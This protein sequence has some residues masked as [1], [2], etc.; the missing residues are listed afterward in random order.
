MRRA[1]L[2]FWCLVTLVL[3]SAGSGA[4]LAQTTKPAGKE[5]IYP[6]LDAAVGVRL[7]LN[8]PWRASNWSPEP[9]ARQHAFRYQNGAIRLE[10]MDPGT[11]MAWQYSMANPI[12]LIENPIAVLRYRTDNKSSVGSILWIDDGTGPG[13]GGAT[14]FTRNELITDGQVHEL[15]KDVR[16]LFTRSKRPMGKLMTGL[17]WYL[18]CPADQPSASIDILEL[19]F[20]PESALLPAETQP[21]KLGNTQTQP[22]VGATAP[23]TSPPPAAAIKPVTATVTDQA[24]NPIAGATI[25]VNAEYANHA[26]NYTTD[27]KGHATL[28]PPPAVLADPSQ[29]ERYDLQR[30]FIVNTHAP[31]Y[32]TLRLWL[33][34]Q[35]SMTVSDEFE[36]VTKSIIL[37]RISTYGGT[38]RN[39]RDEPIPGAAV[40]LKLTP[41]FPQGSE[42]FDRST[43]TDPQGRWV[44]ADVP[45]NAKAEVLVRHPD[46]VSFPPDYTIQK[47]FQ[48]M[49]PV[50]HE[51]LQRQAWAL[52]LKQGLSVT[53]TVVDAQ[54]NPVAGSTICVYSLFNY[55]PYYRRPRQT[56]SDA[57]GV[58]A[59]RGL[60]EEDDTLLITGPKM[61]PKIQPID[62]TSGDSSKLRI[63]LQPARTLLGKIVDFHGNP[64]SGVSVDVTGW[65]G[66]R[67]NIITTI[68][69]SN[70]QGEFSWTAAPPEPM[71]LNLIKSGYATKHDVPA[72]AGEQRLNFVLHKFPK[73]TIQAVDAVSGE[74]VREFTAFP[75]LLSKPDEP[76]YWQTYSPKAAAEGKYVMTVD[77]GDRTLCVQVRSPKYQSSSGD[78]LAIDR[79]DYVL[80]IKLNPAPVRGGVVVDAQGKPCGGAKLY[81]IISLMGGPVFEGGKYSTNMGNPDEEPQKAHADDAGRFVAPNLEPQEALVFVHDNGYAVVMPDKIKADMTVKL[82]PWCSVEGYYYRGSKPVAGAEMTGGRL[83]RE[84]LKGKDLN[85]VIKWVLCTMIDSTITDEKGYFQLRFL[86]AGEISIDATSKKIDAE[87]DRS[88]DHDILNVYMDLEP[89]QDAKIKLGGSGRP[90]VGKLD[91]PPGFLADK[92]TRGS[93]HIE[94]IPPKAAA[95]QGAPATKLSYADVRRVIYAS[96]QADGS[97]RVEDLP[98][99]DYII[100]GQ[101]FGPEGYHRFLKHR[102]TVAPIPA[103]HTNEP[104]DLGLLEFRKQVLLT[105]GMPAPQLKGSLLDGKPFDLA[106]YQAKYV[107]L[108]YYN[109]INEEYAIG[110]LSELQAIQ[111]A[112]GLDPRLEIVSVC[113]HDDPAAVAR[114]VRENKMTWT[115]AVVPPEAWESTSDNWRSKSASYIWF[116]GPGGK[117]VATDLYDGA[118]MQAVKAELKKPRPA[119]TQPRP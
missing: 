92:E 45:E 87:N 9:Y 4:A 50:S 109:L 95:T 43:Q 66:Q 27:A 22:A 103:G 79:G 23:A 21:T 2:T 114:F 77:E 1:F 14:I 65:G 42:S 48:E 31:G 116:I 54:G 71:Q 97:F 11:G 84:P 47:I 28:A 118:R 90:V 113:S 39:E 12:P 26:V 58:F 29:P 51:L 88:D 40:K 105:A 24:G 61:A 55:D 20:A 102:F 35:H 60:S 41:K 119:A 64:V 104:L 76:I 38:I 8:Q 100:E 67:S 30:G 34:S 83:L 5:A 16:P 33:G 46:Y 110:H 111:K 56:Q 52:V 94:T 13:N 10:V 91:A 85:T 82:T 107:L 117:I 108:D 69:T 86:P 75:G 59:I 18:G 96:F 6:P 98:E 106:N 17:C 115:Q 68:A 7:E 101:S 53:G 70:A 73:I 74:P 81:S 63:E 15:R 72:V 25:V 93:F 99:G 36:L 37:S 112:Y 44:I 62:P 32:G 80:T 57:Q 49:A 3:L 78:V 19:R 89:G